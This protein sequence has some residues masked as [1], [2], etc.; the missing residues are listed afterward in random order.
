ME[1]NASSLFIKCSSY[2]QQGKHRIPR[3]SAATAANRTGRKISDELSGQGYGRNNLEI[4]WWA[5]NKRIQGRHSASNFFF[6]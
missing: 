4:G 3:N 1:E 6:F 5:G 2:R